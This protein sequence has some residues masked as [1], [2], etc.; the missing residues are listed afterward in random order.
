MIFSPEFTV[1]DIPLNEYPR[2]QF[3]RDSYLSL[4]GEWDYCIKKDKELPTNYDGKILV[5]YSPESQLSGV[6]RQLQADEFLFYRRAFIL[7]ENFNKEKVLLNVGACDQIANVFINGK[8]VG[9]H[10][11]GYLSFSFDISDYL[12]E[13]EN[14]IIFIV[15]DDASSD[16][17]G[18]GKQ[19]YKRGGI[20]YTA[21][22]G[23]WQSVWLENVPTNYLSSVKL[24]PEFDTKKLFVTPISLSDGEVYVEIL[25]GNNLITS[26]YCKTNV[27][28][29]ID[30]SKCKEWSTE[31]PEL[32]RVVMTFGDDVVESYFGL[33]KFSSI[34]IDNKKYFALNNKPIFHNGLLDQ[35][36]WHD[37]IYTPK[38]NK[39]M[40]N[41]I[42][43]IKDL[44]FN[45]LRK[46]IKV[47]PMLWYYYCDILGVLVWQD[48]ING[49]G[50]YP[51]YRIALCPF[52]NL[53]LDDTNYK[54]MRRSEASREW[55]YTE[56]IGLI[57]QLYNCV[58]ICLWT[59][60]NEAWGQF[61]AYETWKKLVKIDD[62]RL[63]DHASGWQDQGGGDLN[64]RH[65]YFRKIKMKN[66]Y[67]RILALT[68]FGGYSYA[69]DGHVFTKK[70]F[71]YKGYKNAI[72]L[73]NAYDKLYKTEIFPAIENDGLSATVYTQVSDVEDEING[74]YT[75]DRILKFDGDKL[76]QI[77]AELYDIFN[78]TISK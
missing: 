69:L 29:D 75:Y 64:S 40:Y 42:K 55:Y 54:K 25:D 34:V 65:I 57:E 60:F 66:D 17:Y 9:E 4:N 23:I 30:V 6:N 56:A 18:R 72:D 63:Y 21:T 51:F 11:G 52:F 48:M 43:N 16:V 31:S 70:K 3:M 22:S 39:A 2:P 53:K 26:K 13:N 14:E 78:K 32:Y 10:K 49:G 5:P 67:R 61:D 58:S 35:G 36:Y 41:E 74:L 24:L 19:K 44:G 27:K 12:T 28:T 8:L 50:E 73:Q 71:G 47:E 45:M 38:S 15:T 37:G 7:P 59:P 77:N 1:S 33:R 68:E 46:H 20:W 62:S 76:K